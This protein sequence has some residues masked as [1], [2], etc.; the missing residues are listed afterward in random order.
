MKNKLK[1]IYGLKEIKL[2]DNSSSLEIWYNNL[3]NKSEDEIIISDVL[4]MI[5]QNLFVE[6]ALRIAIGILK[7]DPFAGEYYNGELLNHLLKLDG[8]LF[9]E[10]TQD[11]EEIMIIS[12]QKINKL[13]W[14]SDEDR[15]EFDRNSKALSERIK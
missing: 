8:Q 14:E 6:L 1:E 15:E 2:D 10:Y 9:A 5:R 7:N 13:E 4:K 3:I 12:Q 11:I